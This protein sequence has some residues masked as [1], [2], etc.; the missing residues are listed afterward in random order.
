MLISSLWARCVRHWASFSQMDTRY[1]WND[2]G[3][4]TVQY[5]DGREE[6]YVHDDTARLVRQVAADGGEQLKAYDPQGRLIAEQDALGAVTEYR[7]DEVGRLIALIPSLP[8]MRLLTALPVPLRLAEPM[9][10]R[11]STLATRV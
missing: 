10:I 11:F 2:A 7:Y 4:V 9:R 8:V 1:I 6:V 5:V 3:S